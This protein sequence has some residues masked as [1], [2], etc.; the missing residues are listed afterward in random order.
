M[1]HLI[2]EYSDNLDQDDASI[3]VLF[4]TLIKTAVDTGLFPLKGLRC[5]AYKC[6]QHRMAD[7]NPDH[8]FAHLEIK[9]GVGRSMEERKSAADALFEV[10]SAHFAEQYEQHGMAISFEMRE[11]EAIL[12]FNNNN[13]Q[14]FL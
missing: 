13:M 14:K 11:L 6:Q 12:K 2:L 7:G 4:E 5:R 3:Q 10:Y 9:L 1:A 8:G